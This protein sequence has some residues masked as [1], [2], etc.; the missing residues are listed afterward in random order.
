MIIYKTKNYEEFLFIIEKNKQNVEY[1]FHHIIVW[2]FFLTHWLAFEE[3][4]IF[5]LTCKQEDYYDIL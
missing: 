5:F 4:Y 3:F 2:F 1:D